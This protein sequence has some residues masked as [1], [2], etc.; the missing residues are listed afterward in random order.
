MN[1]EDFK[2]DFEVFERGLSNIKSVREFGHINLEIR[3]RDYQELFSSRAT[4]D[5]TSFDEFRIFRK[6]QRSIW[7]KSDPTKLTKV[8]STNF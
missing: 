4:N 5:V 8:A 3:M 2:S 7:T 1:S 6:F